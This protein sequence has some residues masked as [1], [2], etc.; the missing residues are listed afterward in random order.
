MSYA[1]AAPC[2]A[3]NPSFTYSC[4]IELLC[5]LPLGPL[6]PSTKNN[7]C[8]L[9]GQ[10][11]KQ[12]LSADYLKSKLFSSYRDISKSWWATLYRDEKNRSGLKNTSRLKNKN[13]NF[14][15]SQKFH[16]NKIRPVFSSFGS[17]K[18]KPTTSARCW[19]TKEPPYEFA[20][21]HGARVNGTISCVS[22]LSSADLLWHLEGYIP[23]VISPKAIMRKWTKRICDIIENRDIYLTIYRGWK[24][25]QSSHLWPGSSHTKP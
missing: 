21:V 6:T 7:L 8:R 25:S 18:Q 13:C 9:R 15:S 1:Y 2:K 10:R 23:E 11:I 14:E 4:V 24:K 12:A 22:Q 5:P 3:S 19:I 20:N 17:E 16:G